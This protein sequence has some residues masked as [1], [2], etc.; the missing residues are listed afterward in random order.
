MGGEGSA[1]MGLC[2]WRKQTLA[3]VTRSKALEAYN[4]IKHP[5]HHSQYS[6]GGGPKNDSNDNGNPSRH[7]PPRRHFR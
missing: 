3:P 6:R 2:T 4:C 7:R 1:G 5:M